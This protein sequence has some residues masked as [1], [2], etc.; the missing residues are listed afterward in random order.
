MRI[1]DGLRFVL[2]I[3]VA[4]SAP[5]CVM[6]ARVP[7]VRAGAGWSAPAGPTYVVEQPAMGAACASA[8]PC[9]PG[10]V[11][12][13]ED[14]T[15][16][17][18]TTTIASAG[19]AS[20]VVIVESAGYAG[21]SGIVVAGGDASASGVV[22]TS[23]DASASGV[24]ATGGDASASGVVVTGGDASASSGG[25]LVAAGDASSAGALVGGADA[26]ASVAGGDASASG[27]VAITGQGRGLL[28]IAN[29]GVTIDGAIA[30]LGLLGPLAGSSFDASTRVG[31]DGSITIDASLAHDALPGAGG[32][33]SVVVRVAGG[34]APSRVPPLRVHLV[35]DAST[36]MQSTW[37]HL[38]EAALHL[39][40]RL[41]PEDE[42]QIVVYGTDA[43]EALAPVRVGDGSS[44]RRVIRALRP[45]GRTN[46]EAGLR[47]AYREVRPHASL[48]VVLSDGVPNGGLST[49][50]ELGA[51]SAEANARGAVTTA[52][53]IGWDF[54]PGI[55]RALAERG[56][57]RFRIAPRAG[58]LGAILE[59]EL[60]ARGRV[61]AHDIDVSIALGAGVRIDGELPAGVVRTEGGVRIAAPS[62]ASG[63]EQVVVV[64]VMVPPGTDARAIARIDA[65]WTPAGAGV[66]QHADKALAV[67]VSRTPVLAGGA[68]AALD[69]D[70]SASLALAAE[71]VTNGDAHAASVALRDHAVRARVQ[72]RARRDVALEA[73]AGHVETLAIALER[74]VPSASWHDRRALG[75][76]MLSFS[77]S[78][79]R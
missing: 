41:R 64:P 48:V 32:Q 36:S 8:G 31:G 43:R 77:V 72:V 66:A 79:G 45:D 56:R 47:I 46:I 11:V 16:R 27:G 40:A 34:H 67:A 15:A 75:A 19:G 35:I 25:V 7:L 68:L 1:D 57:G 12:V 4:A 50:D 39:V 73:R 49:P 22:V 52:I 76:S 51:L 24:V 29:E 69:A 23:G 78:L 6:Y 2:A 18:S 21:E 26:S 28:A 30:A 71:A 42:L 5:G 61:A 44:A 37:A 14:T 33:T 20:G 10:G 63:E 3:A 70:L 54:H 62:I 13:V 59:A 17:A 53:G 60:A 38:Q 55:L 65:R 58:E 74:L 9:A